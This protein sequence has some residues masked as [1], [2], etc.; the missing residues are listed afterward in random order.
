MA[1]AGSL[2]NYLLDEFSEISSRRRK[3]KEGGFREKAVDID[4]RFIKGYRTDESGRRIAIVDWLKLFTHDTL[5]SRRRS[6]ER[7][8]RWKAQREARGVS[9]EIT[10]EGEPSLVRRDES[11]EEIDELEADK[12][13]E[14][15]PARDYSNRIRPLKRRIEELSDDRKSFESYLFE[16]ITPEQRRVYDAAIAGNLTRADISKGTENYGFLSPEEAGLEYTRFVQWIN[17][18]RKWVNN[19]RKEK[20]A[21]TRPDRNRSSRKA[22]I[23]RERGGLTREISSDGTIALGLLKANGT[24]C[25]L[26]ELIDAN[27]FLDRAIFAEYLEERLSK[28]ERAFLNEY[29]KRGLTR[30]VLVN[31]PVDLAGTSKDI[32]V[33]R[34]DR[35]RRVLEGFVDFYKGYSEARSQSLASRSSRPVTATQ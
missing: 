30:Q 27:A 16:R 8:A 4:T 5:E 33:V 13:D 26:Q 24:A 10:Y 7:L 17:C 14:D 15:K 31:N 32:V 9:E 3:E 23:S 25:D 19:Q 29:H 21:N 34:Y 11:L 28:G 12:D 6:E 18:F 2:A 35:V 1:T 22:K 20:D